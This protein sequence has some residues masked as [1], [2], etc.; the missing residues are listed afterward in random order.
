MNIVFYD[1]V[2]LVMCK[3]VH[4]HV[5]IQDFPVLNGTNWPILVLDVWEH[6]YY[7]KHHYK[8]ADYV[9]DWWEVVCWPEVEKLRLFWRKRT[10]GQTHSEL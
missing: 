9:Q 3:C 8:R 10:D 5:Y 1:S 6:A 2:E 4:I 7:L